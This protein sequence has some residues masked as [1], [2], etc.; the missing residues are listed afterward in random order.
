MR[1]ALEGG[2]TDL[3]I[4]HLC[5]TAVSV[6]ELSSFHNSGIGIHDRVFAVI[7]RARL[8]SRGV[9]ALLHFE[10]GLR[11]LRAGARAD[12]EVTC[13]RRHPGLILGP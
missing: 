4:A 1:I 13:V 2:K 8:A 10:P 5:E 9:V 11:D 7:D 3:D 6:I 12:F